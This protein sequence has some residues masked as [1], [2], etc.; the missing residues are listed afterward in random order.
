M[1]AAD[2]FLY[3]T[4]MNLKDHFGG[5]RFLVW[6][7]IA[8]CHQ[9]LIRQWRTYSVLQFDED[10]PLEYSFGDS[11]SGRL[12][13]V[14]G[15]CAWVTYPGPWFRFGSPKGT[16]RTHRYVA[17]AGPRVQRYM[18][19]GLI[20]TGSPPPMYELARPARFAAE[21][22]ELCQCLGSRLR[23]VKKVTYPLAKTAE[24][25]NLPRAVNLLES[26]LLRLHE[27]VG[28]ES[29]DRWAEAMNDLVHRINQNPEADWDFFDEARNM[30]VCYG[31]FRH[32]FTS[33]LG[34][35]PGRFLQNARLE[36]AAQM[37]RSTDLTIAEIAGFVGIG[38]I[39][40]FNKLFKRHHNMPPG[41]YRREVA[42]KP[43]RRRRG[44]A[45]D[46]KG[47]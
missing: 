12:R 22:R 20:A 8:N 24:A 13:R 44:A 45:G 39:Y 35:P 17:F 9:F 28:P 16:T 30:H 25:P 29:S 18:K 47:R 5:I 32:L 15:A 42:H 41:R 23:H 7:E 11:A 10:G 36:L 1:D 33:R 3:D 38:D 19:T 37:L 31:Y 14:E 40:Y 21:M 26:L 46:A 4:D 27:S 34:V 2:C 6:D 43:G